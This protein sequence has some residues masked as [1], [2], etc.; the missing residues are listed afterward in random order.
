MRHHP[1]KKYRSE[2]NKNKTLPRQLLRQHGGGEEACAQKY[3]IPT[4]KNHL[5]GV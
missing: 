4:N 2:D 3:E 5:P 1:L